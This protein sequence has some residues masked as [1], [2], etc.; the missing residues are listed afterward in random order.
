MTTIG[1]DLA[2]IRKH[3]G[4][5]LDDVHKKTRLP[6][7]TLKR[8]EDDSLLSDPDENIIYVRS[9]IRTYA[10]ALKIK[11]DLAVKSLDQHEVGI[12]NGL[13]LDAY[14]D[15]QPK[16]RSKSDKPEE[17][18]QTKKDSASGVSGESKKKTDKPSLDSQSDKKV[19]RPAQAEM[20]QVPVSTSR[21]VKD[22]K[23][24]EVGHMV[25]SRQ[26]SIPVWIV[27]VI[28]IIVIA[29]TSVYFIID[30]DLFNSVGEVSEFETTQPPPAASETEGTELSL[31][32]AD[33]EPADPAPTALADTLYIT[34]YAAYD[35]L[36][37]V[38]VWSDIKPRIDPYW[39][40]EGIA[41]NFEFRD[42]IRISGQYS[43]MLMFLNGHRINN[44]RQEYYNQ[45]E[46]AVE[47]TRDL[48]ESDIEEWS[49][50]VPLDLPENVSEPDSLYNR[51][52]F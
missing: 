41:L 18:D 20:R 38:R 6:L 19:T 35:R 24:A 40:E 47:L 36:E 13:L 30:S 33:Q 27:G 45:E 42:T 22:E 52:A 37:P 15:L 29:L 21:V 8:I 46:G 43:H 34:L 3:L 9:F 7:D 16:K 50:P 17:S 14:P 39:V 44:F 1:K 28:V 26:N 25:H 12:Y 32:L 49:T 31:D 5:E 51:P 48:F 10:K 4:F 2:A 23:W 11:E